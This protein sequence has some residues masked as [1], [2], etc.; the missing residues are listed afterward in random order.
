[1]EHVTNVAFRVGPWLVEPLLNR[2]SNGAKTT[3]VEPKVMQVLMFLTAHAGEVVTRDQLFDT[4]WAGTVVTDDVLTRSISELRK[5]FND[6]PRQPH[7]IETIPKTGY[8]LIAP[9][10]VDHRG[11]SAPQVPTTLEVALAPTSIVPQTAPLSR[12]AV[13]L[14]GAA[15]VLAVVAG[16][17][18][19]QRSAEPPVAWQPVP[20]T[21]YAGVEGHPAL[22]PDGNQLAFSWMEEANNR[23]LYVKLV[24]SESR[25]RLTDD[26]G[27]DL[28]PAW[29]PDGLRI[30]YIR[31]S[32]ETGCMIYLVAAISTLR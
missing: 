12:R 26:P 19:L 1:M 9:V 7:F 16:F 23:D 25:L 5:A 15:V 2:I 28:N 3:K 20:L 8:R 13:V 11:D 29:S 32:R 6:S 27:I 17:I 4:V 21:T 18:W 24:G 14:L 31:Y 30:A 10:T 22:S